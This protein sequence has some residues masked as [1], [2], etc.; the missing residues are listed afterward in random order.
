MLVQF[1]HIKQKFQCVYLRC[2]C[3]ED[4]HGPSPTENS[5][6]KDK[7]RIRRHYHH[8]SVGERANFVEDH[9]GNNKYAEYKAY[10]DELG[11]RSY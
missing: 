5:H 1:T 10:N 4:F 8:D 6:A 3:N 2:T 9:E 7:C 11:D